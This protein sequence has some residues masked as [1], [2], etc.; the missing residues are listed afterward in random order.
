METIDN[1]EIQK[2]VPEGFKV[3]TEGK[4]NILYHA[5]QSAAAVNDE[6]EQPQPKPK[7]KKGEK[8]SKEDKNKNK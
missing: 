5:K 2:E 6:Q 8:M 1:V 3:L 7:K 4:A